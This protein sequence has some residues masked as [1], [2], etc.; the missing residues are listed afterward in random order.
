[1][2]ILGIIVFITIALMLGN[3]WTA[4]AAG[5]V[6]LVT[7]TADDATTPPEGSLRAVFAALAGD[8]TETAVVDTIRFDSSL[9]GNTIVMAA[10]IELSGSAKTK[11]FVLDGE[12]NHIVI[13]G[14]NSVQLLHFISPGYRV[15]ISNLTLANGAS[16]SSTGVLYFGAPPAAGA[17]VT[18]NNVRFEGNSTTGS[19]GGAVR[20]VSERHNLIYNSGMGEIPHL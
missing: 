7:T 3:Y 14:N 9:K 20:T 6:R 10:P 19:T 12:D 11:N 5:T 8:G 4:N 1:L 15:E 17:T 13:S 2:R 18:L 16:G